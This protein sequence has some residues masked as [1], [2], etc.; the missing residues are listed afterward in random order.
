MS[1]GYSPGPA[2]AK[3]LDRGMAHIQS[4]PYQVSL[5]W[6]FYRLLQDGLLDAKSD[7]KKLVGYTSKARKN[8]YGGW[9]PTTLADESRRSVQRADGF[10]DVGEWAEAVKKHGVGCGL[11]KYRG[12]ENVV[13]IA[14]EARAMTEQFEEYT[15]G[16]DLW[17]FAG[18]ASI[19]YKWDLA[20]AIGQAAEERPV[21]LIYFGD[22][23]DKGL[24]IG[25]AAARD[26]EAWAGCD[27]EFIRAGLSEE[28]VE[29]LGVPENPERPGQYQWEALTDDQ[30]REII[31]D[32]VDPLWDAD[33]YQEVL[34]EQDA[35]HDDLLRYLKG[36]TIE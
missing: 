7:Y 33:A 15:E 36:W 29:R 8:F 23:D 20:Q 25:D 19:P 28:Q 30:A 21:T 17:P 1:E 2:V 32:A 6:L 13:I 12:Q 26:I 34:T 27:F 4:V 35:A 16:V 18:D 31:R 22:L 3:I 5:R 11:S 14:Y 24:Q 9:N 10:S